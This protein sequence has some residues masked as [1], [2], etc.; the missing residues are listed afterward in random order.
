MKIERA[1][2]QFQPVVIT[3]ETQEEVD[4]MYHILQHTEIEGT[5]TMSMD[6]RIFNFL[7]DFVISEYSAE[8]DE[9]DESIRL[10]KI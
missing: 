8:Y 10:T 2:T 9:V 1:G 4:Q 7:E 5:D 6:C 3:L